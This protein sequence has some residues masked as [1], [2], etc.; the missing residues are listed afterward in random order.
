MIEVINIAKYNRGYRYLLT[1]VDVFSK[2]AWLQ[3]VKNKT[4]QAVTAAFEKILKEGRK[5][6]NLQTD[7]GKEFYNK[8]FQALMKRKGIHHFST[9]GDTKASVVERFNRTLKQR[10][11]QYFTVKNTLNFVPVLQDL[12]QGYNRSY[13]HSIKRAPNEVTETNSPRGVGDPLWKEERDKSE[14]TAVQ[15]RGSCETQQEVQNVQEMLFTP[16]GPRRCLW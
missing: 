4:G 6:I 1:V 9:S 7:D 11:Y 2:H 8:T 5:P 13:H 14:E 10:L 12:V 3:P 15:G 16:V